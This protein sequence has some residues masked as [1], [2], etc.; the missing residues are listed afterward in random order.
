MSAP[1]A[2]LLL[3]AGAA[4]LALW[5]GWLLL[6]RPGQAERQAAEAGAAVVAAEGRAK[7]AADAAPIIERHYQTVREIERATSDG[8]TGVLAAEG[9]ADRVPAAVD[10]AGRAA[11]CLQ[12]LYRGDAACQQL[13]GADP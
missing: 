12:P 4:A 11:L 13:P 7:A 1:R 10:R 6:I 3:L 2:R 8:A 5:L 9:A